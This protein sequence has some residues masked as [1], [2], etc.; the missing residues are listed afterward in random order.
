[1]DRTGLAVR[2]TPEAALVDASAAA[3]A[4]LRD[5]LA[6]T[7]RPFESQDISS[8]LQ[9]ARLAVTVL[10][11]ANIDGSTGALL[12][13]RRVVAESI[14]GPMHPDRFRVHRV[15]RRHTS[16]ETRPVIPL[17]GDRA[18]GTNYYHWLVDVLPRAYAIDSVPPEKELVILAPP[19]PAP[20]VTETLQTLVQRSPNM[21]VRPLGHREILRTG[22]AWITTYPMGDFTAVLPAALVTWLRRTFGREREHAPGSSEGALKLYVRRASDRPRHVANAA[23]VEALLVSYGFRVLQPETLTV[24]QQAELFSS[25]AVVVGGHGAALAN[26]VFCSGSRVLEFCAP[27]LAAPHYAYLSLAAGNRWR[28]LWCDADGESGYVVD[29][30]ELE[31][32][33]RRAMN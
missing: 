17:V 10:R 33:V 5:L 19:S 9:Q 30:E 15:R 24:A 26:T 22:E 14:V 29:L 32:A 27:G 6:A 4:D 16:T 7:S 13:G 11:D 20:F 31:R 1:M 12:V 25:A 2:S 3:D 23:E 8:G 18:A 28:P 21:V